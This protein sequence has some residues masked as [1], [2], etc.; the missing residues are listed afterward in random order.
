MK[1]KKST[2]SRTKLRDHVRKLS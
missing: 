1:N 2:W